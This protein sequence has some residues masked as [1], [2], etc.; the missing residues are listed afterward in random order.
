MLVTPV[1][2]LRFKVFDLVVVTHALENV[3][4][5]GRPFNT[6]A[7]YKFR[8]IPQLGQESK[9]G[10]VSQDGVRLGL[11]TIVD[12]Q[13]IRNPGRNKVGGDTNTGGV[14]VVGEFLAVG[15]CGSVGVVI[16]HRKRMRMPC[17]MK[18][19]A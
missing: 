16:L 5:G 7:E 9:N 3:L 1:V 6:T 19:R 13:F 11:D 15:S 18:C 8:K 14:K 4:K 2:A 17:Q 10:G 12:N